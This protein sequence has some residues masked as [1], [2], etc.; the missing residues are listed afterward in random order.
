M[1]TCHNPKARAELLHR[2]LKGLLAGLARLAAVFDD[3][4]SAPGGPGGPGCGALVELLRRLSRE[5]SAALSDRASPMGLET[6]LAVAR[7]RPLCLRL[8]RPSRRELL[9]AGVVGF[10]SAVAGPS[11]IAR[12]IGSLRPSLLPR[13]PRATCCPP[14]PRPLCLIL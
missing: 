8:F 2:T 10:W 13:P 12:G 1:R 3:P 6:R 11:V 9:A 7:C 4:S 14:V 5:L